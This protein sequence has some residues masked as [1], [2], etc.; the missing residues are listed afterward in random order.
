MT[1]KRMTKADFP[2]IDELP[3]YGVDVPVPTSFDELKCE[4]KENEGTPPLQFEELEGYCVPPEGIVSVWVNGVGSRGGR[5]PMVYKPGTFRENRHTINKELGISREEIHLIREE[6]LRNAAINGVR[7][8]LEKNEIEIHG[9]LPADTLEALMYVSVDRLLDP[10]T[11]AKELRLL[12]F[13]DIVKVLGRKEET[14][15]A[16]R[17]NLA[18]KLGIKS[19][20]SMD[21][22]LSALT[23]LIAEK[24]GKVVDAELYDVED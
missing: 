13:Q 1:D 17:E 18:M 4:Y 15:E 16:A 10:S 23:D 9:N 12:A 5:G 21:D 8:A 14:T 20:E 6:T 3:R 24:K 11:P 7:R 22:A 2:P 19:L